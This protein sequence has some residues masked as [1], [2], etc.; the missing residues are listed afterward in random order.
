MVRTFFTVVA[1]FFASIFAILFVLTAVPTLLLST[2]ERNLFEADLYKHAFTEGQLYNRLP[3][4]LGEMLVSSATFNPCEQNPVTCEEVPPELSACYT[5]VLGT[6]RYITLASGKG[7]PSESEQQKIQTCQEQYGAAAPTDTA[8]NIEDQGG[9]PPFM[10]NL[11]AS[12]WES[13]IRSVLPPEDL[14]AMTEGALDQVFDYLNGKT[15]SAK[16]SLVRLKDRLRGPAG[17]EAMTQLFLAQPVCTLEQVAQ[18]IVGE[19]E[20]EEEEMIFCNPGEEVLTLLTPLLQEQLAAAASG[21][22]DEATI[23]KPAS[24]SPASTNNG[25]FG[26]D[27]LSGLRTGRWVMRWSPLLPFG[28]LL[29]VTLFGVRS[30]KSWMRWWGI[31]FFFTGIITLG[32]GIATL[33][34]FDWTW[35]T[36]LATRIPPYLSINM[37]GLG[38]ELVRAIVQGLTSQVV[39]LAHLLTIIGL[40]AWIGSCFVRTKVKPQASATPSLP[41]QP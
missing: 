9:M 8:D 4:I 30:L 39:L 19:G 29:L 31:P 41:P 6:D 12:D 14:Q 23:I 15:I 26:N 40:A 11:T 32:M 13:I 18:M 21:I 24:S 7:Q 16:I 25:P 5:Q 17:I 35:G 27:P 36:F 10:R 1:R 3:G 33:P 37:A 22:P 38:R 2:V 28:F 34:V 20:E